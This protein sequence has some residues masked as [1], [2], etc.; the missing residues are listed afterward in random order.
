MSNSHFKLGSGVF[1]CLNCTRQTR[2]TNG[3]NGKAEMCED[4]HQGVMWDN[5][6]YDSNDAGTVADYQG[7]ADACYQQAV[8]KGGKIEGHAPQ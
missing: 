3:D 4:C 8:N 6:A 1:A 5:G 7:R 2:D